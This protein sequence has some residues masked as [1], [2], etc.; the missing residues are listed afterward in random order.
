MA[1]ELAPD[2]AMAR[3]EIEQARR[4][5]HALAE[6]LRAAGLFELWLPRELGGPELHPADGVAVIEALAMADGA[7]GWCTANA[8]VFSLLAGSLSEA[9]ARTIFDDHGVVAGSVNPTGRADAAAGGFRASGRW[10]YASGIDHATWIVANCIVH[11]DGVPRRTAA[12][13]PE[14]RFLFLPRTAVNVIDTW[15]V[16][17]LRGTGSHDFCLED[18]FVAEAFTM[19]AFAARPLQPGVLYRVPP[20]SLFVVALASVTLGIARA[21]VDALVELAVAKTPMG[22]ATLMRDKPVVQIQTARAE[23]FIRAARAHVLQAIGQ[24]WNEIAGG[25]T[26]SL[27]ARAG[28]RLATSFCAEACAN[29]VDLVHAAAGG[30]AIHESGR[31]ARCFRDLHAATQ[32]IGLNST[33]YEMAGRVLLGLDPGTPRF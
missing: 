18:V 13:S 22:S 5:P 9:V 25:A 17:G 7:V 14:M 11:E 8:A 19:P 27:Q 12:G 30:S 26:A 29:A 15:Q 4:L 3:Q 10:A 33:G 24:Q 6:K 1:H 28:V 2:I 16:S 21:A 20:I 23:A 31:I 32:H